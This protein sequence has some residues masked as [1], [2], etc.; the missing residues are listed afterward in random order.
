MITPIL[1][2]L[3]KSKVDLDKS[4]Q[5]F[6]AM[7]AESLKLLF[8]IAGETDSRAVG[9]WQH[10]SEKGGANIYDLRERQWGTTSDGDIYYIRSGS[11]IRV[12][13]HALLGFRKDGVE[14]FYFDDDESGDRGW[15]LFSVE[16]RKISKQE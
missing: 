15:H 12:G 4:K 2:F 5:A 1:D 6:D 14:A 8:S 7:L 10:V 11:V 9:E 3:L 13:S 16:D